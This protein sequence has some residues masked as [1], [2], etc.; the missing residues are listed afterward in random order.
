LYYISQKGK[1]QTVNNIDLGSRDLAALPELV[2]RM[3]TRLAQSAS[4][5]AV[6]SQ[7]RTKLVSFNQPRLQEA[8]DSYGNMATRKRVREWVGG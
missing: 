4:G 2:M 5:D 7:A 6:L 3:F 8:L 1:S